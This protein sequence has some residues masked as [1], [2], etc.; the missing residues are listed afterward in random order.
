MNVGKTLFAQGMEFRP[1]KTFGRIMERHKGDEEVRMLGV[2]KQLF[3]T[4]FPE[5]DEAGCDQQPCG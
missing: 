1:W 2:L 4:R 5:W 3:F